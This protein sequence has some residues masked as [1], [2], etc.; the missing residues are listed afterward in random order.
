M[1]GIFQIPSALPPGLTLA[2]KDAA[3]NLVP[4]ADLFTDE[5]RTVPF[6]ANPTTLA[7]G[8]QFWFYAATDGYYQAILGGTASAAD[9]SWNGGAAKT[10]PLAPVVR[11]LAAATQ[12]QA[13]DPAGITLLS[14]TAQ[15]IWQA[16]AKWWTTGAGF[17][18]AGNTGKAIVVNATGDGFELAAATGG[19]AI[20]WANPVAITGAATL[21]IG[22]HHVCT[23]TTADYPV[24]LPAVSGNAGKLISVEMS[25]ALTKLVTV[26][27][28]ASETIDG[29]L[30]RVMWAKE[31]AILKCDGTT[32]TKVGGKSI[33]MWVSTPMV[34]P[35]TGASNTYLKIMGN[36]DALTGNK[37]DLYNTTLM[38][39]VVQRPGTYTVT[40]MSGFTAGVSAARTIVS[41]IYKNGVNAGEIGAWQPIGEVTTIVQPERTYN[42]VAGDYFENF[43]LYSAGS[44][45]T[46]LTNNNSFIFRE[47]PTW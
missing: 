9:Q 16:I 3:G 38:R 10:F 32:W 7:A 6:A 40:D 8:G 41:A 20:D 17:T 15:R 24:T 29:E 1:L 44:Y 31:T 18:L 42:L 35:L 22:K 28:N 43:V 26:D 37:T 47:V 46:S 19:G 5:P 13:E 27:G 23:G 39:I 11:P 21:T 33:P 14:W 34:Y 2:V 4:A 45:T 25:A 36:Y 30:T 12:P